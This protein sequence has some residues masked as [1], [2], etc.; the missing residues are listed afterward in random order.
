ML[1]CLFSFGQQKAED[2]ITGFQAVDLSAVEKI[3]EPQV[4]DKA[5]E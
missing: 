5:K 3:E 2:V 1:L 4:G